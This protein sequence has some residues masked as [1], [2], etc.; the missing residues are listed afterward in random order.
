MGDAG[1]HQDSHIKAL[2]MGHFSE[3]PMYVAFDHLQ[4]LTGKEQIC[5][6]SLF[7]SWSPRV[8][9]QKS[10]REGGGPRAEPAAQGEE[11]LWSEMRPRL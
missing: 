11:K 6:Y 7:P 4:G 10:E 5:T 8:G 9:T 3:E 1:G 2:C